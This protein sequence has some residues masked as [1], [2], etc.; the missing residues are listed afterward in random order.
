[1]FLWAP[2]GSILG[3][4][5]YFLMIFESTSKEMNDFCK[6]RI[7]FSTT[8]FEIKSQKMVNF[9][10]RLPS[11]PRLYRAVTC[12]SKTNFVLIFHKKGVRARILLVFEL[13]LYYEPKYYLKMPYN[14]GFDVSPISPFFKG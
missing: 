12:I 11:C 8:I 14:A 2:F 10:A 13:Y 3:L 7:K 6:K 5:N 4:L 1:M 9:D